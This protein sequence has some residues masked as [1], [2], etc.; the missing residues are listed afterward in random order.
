MKI[1]SYIL[2]FI[3]GFYFHSTYSAQI[4]AGLDVSLSAI[5]DQNM[6]AS[7]HLK[8]LPKTEIDMRIL[9]EEGCLKIK[10]NSSDL[11]TEKNF[12]GEKIFNTCDLKGSL[13]HGWIIEELAPVNGESKHYGFTVTLFDSIHKFYEKSDYLVGKDDIVR[14]L[15]KRQIKNDH[16]FEIT[17]LMFGTGAF[18]RDSNSLGHAGHLFGITLDPY[19]QD[20]VQSIL[21]SSLDQPNLRFL[22]ARDA[23]IENSMNGSLASY[24]KT[25]RPWETIG[26]YAGQYYQTKH[27]YVYA[28]G[29]IAGFAQVFGGTGI[30]GEKFVV[31]NKT[32]LSSDASIELVVI[33]NDGT[34]SLHKEKIKAQLNKNEI[35]LLNKALG[36]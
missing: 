25:V 27:E 12:Y 34:Y 26:V 20:Q 33:Y 32:L 4:E 10:I 17:K 9:N 3:L 6:L 35:R 29:L 36:L 24:R 2:L 16:L 1:K 7:F 19:Y 30:I 31:E 15:P 22:K 21:I 13:D 11:K 14:Y 18:F 5:S 28:P 23:F 8:I